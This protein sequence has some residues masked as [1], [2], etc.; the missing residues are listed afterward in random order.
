[1]SNL[2]SSPTF[3]LL[4][5]ALG[6]GLVLLLT[7]VAVRLLRQPARRQRVAEWGVAAALALTLLA[8]AP[9]WLLIPV[10]SPREPIAAAA[11]AAQ[12]EREDLAPAFPIDLLAAE[13]VPE[14]AQESPVPG[15]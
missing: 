11:P 2:L 6:G 10:A 8:V 3:W 12:P 13:P 14:E 9:S 4:R 15:A 1:M 5:V 7:C